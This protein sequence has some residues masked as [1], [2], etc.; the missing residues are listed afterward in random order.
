M[1]RLVIHPWSTQ[2]SKQPRTSDRL[3]I[4]L[5][6]VDALTTQ[7]YRNNA[8][9]AGQRSAW[10]LEPSPFFTPDPSELCREFVR[11]CRCDC[12]G[13]SKSTKRIIFV[14]S[15]KVSSSCCCALSAGATPSS[16][17]RELFLRDVS[18]TDPEAQKLLSVGG[19]WRGQARAYLLSPTSPYVHRWAHLW[20]RRFSFLFRPWAEKTCN[21]RL[22]NTHP[23]SNQRQY[24]A[25]AAPP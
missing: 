4:A 17:G 14:G 25:S 1:T 2:L 18:K 23:G 21:C 3:K 5:H 9:P 11:V 13:V 20:K 8:A 24:P 12:V 22:G 15:F 6:A 10:R 16:I 19:P 7:V